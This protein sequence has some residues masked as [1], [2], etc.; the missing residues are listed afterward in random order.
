MHYIEYFLFVVFGTVVRL[1]PLRLAQRLG[2]TLSTLAYHAIS[3]RRAVALENLREAFP[4]K[5]EPEIQA[6]AKGAFRSFAVAMVELLWF[7]RLTRERID[8]LVRF[9]NL[10][11]L[12]DAHKLGRGLIMMSG[13]FGNWELVALSG[14][15]QSNI[16]FTMIVKTQ[17]NLLIDNVVN[18]YR[19]L[20]GN[21]PVPMGMSVRD[22]FNALRE[23]RVVA[24]AADQSGPMEGL[25]VDFFGRPTATHQG[26]A[27]FSL[28]TGAP[29][30]MGFLVRQKDGTYEGILE[31]VPTEDLTEATEAN[32]A[33]LTRRHVKLLEKYVRMYPDQWLWMHRRWKHS[34]RYQQAQA[35]P[36]R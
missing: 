3:V 28:K 22:I 13:H 20:H 36:A 18:R 17:H 7:P 11:L 10:D 12:V 14:A 27:L 31:E 29:V 35:V 32:I 30:Q 26:P 23:K 25:F 8:K 2:K 21:R 16:P 33:E 5:S 4:E 9:K 34:E 6:I 24:M 15:L 1:F 19:S